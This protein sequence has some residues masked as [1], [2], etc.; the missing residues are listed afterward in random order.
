MSHRPTPDEIMQ[1][2]LGFWGSKTLLSA[3]ELGVFTELARGPA[4]PE[5]LRKRLD[6]HPRSARD[7]FDALVALGMLNREGDQYSNTPETDLY[8][9]R[10]KPS[11]L[12]GML[13]MA[14]ARLYGFWGSLTE[15]LRTGAPQNEAKQGGNFF[16]AIY[17]DP[18]K[19]E[20]FL[21]AMTALSMGAN[22]AI[23]QHF[24]WSD[25]KTFIDIGGA[26]GGLA[27]QVALAN[28]HITGGAF[29][30]PVAAP[31]FDKY[32]ESFGLSERLQFYG[33]NFFEDS[34]PKADVLAMGHVLHDWNLNEKRMLIAKAHKALPEGGA[35]IIFESLIDDDRRENA[36]GL[37]M[38]LNMLI[39]TPGGFDYTGADCRGWLAEAGFRE[40]RVEHLVGPDSMAV[41]IK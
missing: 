13:E 8:L 28:E 41:G 31:F 40:S 26:E 18:A 10:N 35:L 20:G 29:D 37:L 6:L 38:S 3:I 7:F 30:L 39:E 25:Y 5:A 1:L 33:G 22:Q 27:V 11:Y 15:G 23:A 4:D 21:G 14:N 36:F 16:E 24:P 17:G 32:V 19:L 34:I 2:G 9:D 12:A